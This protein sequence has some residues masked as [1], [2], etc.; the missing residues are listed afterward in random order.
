V[1]LGKYE[2]DADSIQREGENIQAV[3]SPDAKLIA[4][5]VS[6]D[7]L[8]VMLFVS[9]YGNFH[10]AKLWYFLLLD[11]YFMGSVIFILY[12]RMGRFILV[13]NVCIM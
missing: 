12:E 6:F 5:L 7:Y 3:W 13:F 2:R 11:M 8:L 4:I 10:V 9:L 1:R